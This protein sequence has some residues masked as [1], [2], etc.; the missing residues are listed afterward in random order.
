MPTI[1]P[2]TTPLDLTGAPSPWLGAATR[3]YENFPVGSW[4]LPRALRPHVAAFYAFARAADDIAD[5]PD[6][7]PDAKIAR[8]SL[9]GEALREG[10]SDL[11]LAKAEALRRSLAQTGVS[12]RHALDLLSAFTQDATK[13]RYADWAELI[14]YCNRSAAPVGRY[15]L[16]L[17]GEDPSGYGPSDALCNALQILNHMQ[18][19]AADFRE[20]DR[21]YVPQD[22]LTAA[23]AD[24]G[25]LARAAASPGLRVTLD[26]MADATAPLV[27]AARRLPAALRSRHLAAESQAIVRVAERLLQRLR[28]QDPL[29]GRVKLSRLEALSCMAA[30]LC[31]LIVGA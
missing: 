14:D 9:L 8:L 1:A 22:W 11:R 2:M 27:Q 6:L 20:L 26:R 16:D 24:T 31:T 25:H 18:D 10:S 30:G 13:S 3:H 21:V 17:H 29:A 12:A 15:L 7:T 28:R 23:G 5:A 4:L 19:C